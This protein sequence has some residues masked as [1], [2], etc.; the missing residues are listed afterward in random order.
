ML[1]NIFQSKLTK[2]YIIVTLIVIVIAL[3]SIYY[4]TSQVMHQS[5]REEIEY[6]NDLLAKSISKKTSFLFEKMVNDTRII[7]EFVVEDSRLNKELYLSEMERVITKNPLYLF[8][9]VENETGDSIAT[10]PNVHSSST[11]LNQIINRLKW[12]KTFYIS[13]LITLDDGRPTIAIAYPII[14]KMGNYNGAVVAYVNLNVLSEYLKQVKIGKK[15]VNALVDR[16]GTI[17]AHT[18]QTFLKYPLNEHPLGDYLNKSKFGI[19][20]GF[21][22]GNYMVFAYRP[23]EEGNFGLIVGEPLQQALAPTYDVQ[24]LLFKGFIFVF[25]ITILLTFIGTTRVVKPIVNLIKQARD[26]KEGKRG[27][28]ELLKTGDELE[29]LSLTMGEM[30]QELKNKEQRLFY[31]LESIPYGVITTDKDGK[32]MTFNK[33]AENLTLY[34]S[35]EAIGKYIIDLPFKETKT[36]FISWKTLKEGKQFNE[37]ESYIL[38]RRGKKHVVRL[39]SSLFT[40]DDKKIIGAILILRD[41]S[42]IKKLE[43]YLK[44]TERLSALGQLTAG[45]A[46]EIKNPLSII[47][48]AAEA[49]QLDSSD[50]AFVSEMTEDIL[51]T[52]DR[53]NDLLTDFLK[54]S[55]GEEEEEVVPTDLIY[56]LN[57][58]LSLLKN[59]FEDKSIKVYQEYDSEHVMIKANPNK[60]TQVF[61]NIILN[62]IHAMSDGG[63]LTI[64]ISDKSQYWYIEIEDSGIGIPESKLEWIFTPFYTTKEEGTGLGLSIAY[65][66]ITQHDGK[67][68]ATSNSGGT[69]ISIQFPK[70]STERNGR[71]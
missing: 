10:I 54:M 65:E 68:S 60:I 57:E 23:I 55:K 45:I 69:T 31:I 64:R 49:I 59:Q 18:N 41:V 44:Q 29:E 24:K 39:Y 67:I 14:N 53:L 63:I 26:Y 30:A 19:W 6:R 20:E 70:L 35:K 36:K 12:S 15:G 58:L 28:Y 47:Q 56:L 61:L 9:S 22:F 25:I 66:I 8:I 33:G 43:E 34:N 17:I 13:N 42:E 2:R 62:S 7:S 51:E 4:I 11:S 37:L 50:S 27:S 21:L 32:V 40:G 16:S 52:T 5:M 48:A 3:T 38:D 46:H 1:N 71:E